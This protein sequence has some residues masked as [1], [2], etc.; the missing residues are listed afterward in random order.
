M[1][2]RKL[3]YENFSIFRINR[4]YAEATKVLQYFAKQKIISY[5]ILFC[6][7]FKFFD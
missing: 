6:N 4:I 1:F 2:L 7:L 3:I 5:I